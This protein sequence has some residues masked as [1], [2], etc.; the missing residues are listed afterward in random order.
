MERPVKPEATERR[1]MPVGKTV[2]AVANAITILRSLARSREPKGATHIAR[3]T[4]INAS[5]CFNILR[6]LEAEDIVAFNPTNKSYSISLGVM[7]IAKGASVVGGDLEVVRPVMHQVAMTHGV[8]VSVWQPIRRERMVLIASSLA[9][10]SVRVQMVVGQRL[11]YLIGSVGRCFAAT[12]GLTPD[13]IRT[14]FD[15]VRWQK[16][17]EFDEYLRQVELARTNGYAIDDGNF[18][19]GIVTIGLPV[20]DEA[21]QPVLGV[22]ATVLKGQFDESRLTELV[23]DLGR[24]CSRL[25]Q[26]VVGRV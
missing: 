13:E 19:V 24:L 23:D 11:P 25:R 15:E 21:G 1:E 26:V 7:E 9:P 22:T 17:I 4:G 20:F 16:P 6:T 12:S 5:T 10:N 3:D 18:R 2:G 8:T 14:L